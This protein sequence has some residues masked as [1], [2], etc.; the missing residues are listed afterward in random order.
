MKELTNLTKYKL[1]GKSGLRVSPLCL[2]TMTFGTKWGWGADKSESQAIFNHYVENGGNF[3]D[4][5]NIYT[6]GESEEYIGEFIQHERESLVVATKYTLNTRKGDPNA[7]G[8]HRKNLIQSVEASLKRLKT[9]YIDLLWLHV[10]EYRTPVDEVMRALDDL[11]KSGKVFYIGV[12]DTPAW[13]VSRSNTMAELMG[14]SRFIALQVQHSLIE[15]TVESDLMPMAM[16]LG[17]G[18]VPWG[19]LGAGLLTGKHTVSELKSD[20][21][22]EINLSRFTAKNEQIISDI[23]QIAKKLN[24]S[25]S[26]V[27]INWILQ[28]PGITSPI[29]G[30]RTLA[31]FKENLGSMQF[32]LDADNMNQL[33]TVSKP[34]HGFPHNFLSGERAVHLLSGGTMV[35]SR[36][37]I[38]L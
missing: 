35:E 23:V 33:N 27:S 8:N 15:R 31:Q 19:I 12:S 2:G 26:Q 37:P 6:N 29:L 11:V 3:I 9:S 16:E 7:G 20:G 18:G 22:R 1:L 13:I 34:E 24:K 30:A 38:G 32:T 4:T 5:A 10:W 21:K 14:W 25:P 36:R 28:Q 17:L